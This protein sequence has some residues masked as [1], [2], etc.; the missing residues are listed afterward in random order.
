MIDAIAAKKVGRP[1]PNIVKAAL[2]VAEVYPIFPTVEKKPAWGNDELGVATGM[3][4]FKIA[5][6]EP[7][8]VRRLFSHPRA[9]EIAVPMG[10]M[11]GL[12]CI[13]VDAYKDPDVEQWLKD[14]WNYFKDTLCHK[15]RSGGWH[16][17]F[18]TLSGV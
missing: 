3:G 16:F 4:G 14:N 6:Q 12:I 17:F 5:T 7:D 9:T 1:I 2:K 10:E 13:D 18:H 15:T 11:S 8:E